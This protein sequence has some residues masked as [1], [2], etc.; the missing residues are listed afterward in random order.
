[1]NPEETVLETAGTA[2]ETAAGAAGAA[3]VLVVGRS[4]SVLAATAELLREKGY[5][6]DVTN[7]FGEVL[8]DYDLADLD[9]LVFGGMIPP[10]TKQHLT[11]ETTRRNAGITLVQGLAG[12][13]GVIAAQVQAITASGSPETGRA[14]Y[15]ETTRTLSLTLGEAE[16]VSIEAL[17]GTSFTPPEP[18][19][20]SMPVFAGD[21]AAGTHDIVLPSQVPDVASFAAVTIGSLVQVLTLGAM[22]Q[23]VTRMRPTSAEDR[24]LPDVA[25]ISTHG[26]D[27]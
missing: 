12:I 20:T 6:A 5:R 10:D 7:Q 26:A 23:A 22:P 17:W 14:A 2:G 13:P 25:A 18:K 3:R 15:D 8:A 9:V 4:P 27:R 24:R 1:M 19:S 11:E 21:L 16:H